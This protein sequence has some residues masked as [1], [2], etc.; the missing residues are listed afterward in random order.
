M[1]HFDEIYEIAAS[2]Q[3]SVEALEAR[4][5]QGPRGP[6][7][8][9]TD[10]A[11]DRWLA[12]L[13]RCIFQAGFQ[14]KVIEAKWKGFEDAFHGFDIGYNSMMDDARF[15]ALIQDTRIVRNGAKIQT[16][17]D[18]AAFLLELRKDGGAGKVLGGWPATDYIGLLEMLRKRGSRLGG[19]TGQYAMRFAGRDAF[20]LSQDVTARLIAEGVIDKPATS[21]GALKKV[22]EAFNTW[23]EHSGRSLTEMSR[24]LAMSI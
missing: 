19:T 15:D 2:R 22:Q 6:A 17:C 11:E 8:D 13:T 7:A 16:V 14:W 4:L 24:I 23:G 9:I 18:N 5:D 3:G 10:L 1:R 21:K 20:V 12:T